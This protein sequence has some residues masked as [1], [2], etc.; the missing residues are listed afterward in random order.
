MECRGCGKECVDVGFGRCADCAAESRKAV[1][2]ISEEKAIQE[3]ETWLNQKIF[4][5]VSES[6]Y[7]RGSFTV[8]IIHASTNGKQYEGVGFSKARQDISIARYDPE[9]GKAVSR[10]RSIHDLFSEY[11]KDIK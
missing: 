8:H 7:Q 6:T 5:E 10:G 1:D 3:T 2:L 4:N 11:K 9:R